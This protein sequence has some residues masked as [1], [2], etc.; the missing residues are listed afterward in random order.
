MAY[1]F[2]QTQDRSQWPTL[3]FPEVPELPLEEQEIVA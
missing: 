3:A 1:V 2:E